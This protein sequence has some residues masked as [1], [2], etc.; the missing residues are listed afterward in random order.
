M[1]AKCCLFI[2]LS[3]SP[4]VSVFSVFLFFFFFNHLGISVP[5]S[6]SGFAPN[7]PPLSLLSN[8]RS[9]ISYRVSLRFLPLPAQLTIIIFSL[10]WPSFHTSSYLFPITPIYNIILNVYLLRILI[11]S[12]ICPF[13][14][15]LSSLC[16]LFTVFDFLP[17]FH[18]LFFSYLLLCMPP[19][20]FSQLL[21]IMYFYTFYSPL[22]IFRPSFFIFLFIDIFL[23]SDFSSCC[24][25]LSCR[26]AC[27]I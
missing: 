8:C 26:S 14:M 23:I 12:R 25:P 2:I 10:P 7:P 4:I 1:P 19:V 17:G 13:P 9:C 18:S 6:L 21:I 16:S 11:S 15:F 27:L 22:L 5:R 3:V 24:V 20:S